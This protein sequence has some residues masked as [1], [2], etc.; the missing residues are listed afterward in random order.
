MKSHLWSRCEDE[1]KAF[2][3][4]GF[5][6]PKVMRSLMLAFGKKSFRITI[7]FFL[8]PLP[9]ASSQLIMAFG[10]GR[11]KKKVKEFVNQGPKR[12]EK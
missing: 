5:L 4:S 12:H 1:V 8:K 2:E 9:K 6:L 7:H 10:S 3:K 11:R